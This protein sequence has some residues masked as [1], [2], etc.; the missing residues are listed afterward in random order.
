MATK[1]NHIA[2]VVP[3]LE[4]GTGFWADALGLQ[5]SKVE[6]VPEQ[7]VRVAFLPVGGSHIELLEPTDNDS[8]VARYLQKNGPGLHHICLEVDNIAESLA[9][10]KEANVQ[11]IDEEPRA[12]HDGIQLA[13]IHPR[14]TGGTLV[15]LYQ[16]PPEKMA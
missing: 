6:T 1:I 8:G 3:D 4:E 14:A 15:E 11:L 5:V 10:L 16:L 7:R 2:I 13:F 12:G 9:R